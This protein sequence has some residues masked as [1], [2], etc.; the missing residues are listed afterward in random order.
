MFWAVKQHDME[1][2]GR[3]DAPLFLLG[4]S[5]CTALSALS[6]GFFRATPYRGAC[7][8]DCIS[9][10][11]LG[12]HTALFRHMISS[13]AHRWSS[14]YC[15]FLFP[16]PLRGTITPYPSRIGT[17]VT[18]LRE[19]VYRS[20]EYRRW[21]IMRSLFLPNNSLH[22]SCCITCPVCKGMLSITS[23]HSL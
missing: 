1:P 10:S 8:S 3:R 20:G 12:H 5:R 17:Q 15:P 13:T 9:L 19:R 21:L 7:T 18:K 16:H 22:L 23:K 14:K 6:S 4:K 11:V 2:P